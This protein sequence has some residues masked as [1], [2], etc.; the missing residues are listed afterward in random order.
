MRA[1]SGPELIARFERWIAAV[2]AVLDESADLRHGSARQPPAEFRSTGNL[3]EAPL[4]IRDCLLHVVEHSATHLG[5]IQ[6]TVQLFASLDR[7]LLK[8]AGG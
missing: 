4:T 7:G 6:I 3:G 2:H 1:G 5:Q 8:P